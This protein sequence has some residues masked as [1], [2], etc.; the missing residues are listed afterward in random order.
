[1]M[2]SKVNDV[3]LACP[4]LAQV[5]RADELRTKPCCYRYRYYSAA[6]YSI[7]QEQKSVSNIT[8]CICWLST[9]YPSNI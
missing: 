8:P 6:S 7:D 1:M 5:L 2:L 9:H 3:M 4:L